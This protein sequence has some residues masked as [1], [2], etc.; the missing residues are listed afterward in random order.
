MSPTRISSKTRQ[1]AKRLRS[2]QTLGEKFLWR[3]LRELK[4]DGV[5]VRRQAPVGPYV[6]DF[7]CFSRKLMIEID[8]DVHALPENRARDERR[9][10]WLRE[11]GFDIARYSSQDV[12]ENL[13]GVVLDIRTR[14][15]L[16]R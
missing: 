8:G 16:D 5:H 13:E 12:H 4:A 15:G 3:A 7:A 14:L 2:D 10:N 1:A 6:V 9:E 11:Q